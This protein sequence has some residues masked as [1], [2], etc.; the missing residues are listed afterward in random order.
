MDQA[1]DKSDIASENLNTSELDIGINEIVRESS[2]HLNI[3]DKGDQLSDY[4]FIGIELND[5]SNSRSHIFL[6]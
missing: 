5:N 4:R 1:T 6:I 3:K 2:T